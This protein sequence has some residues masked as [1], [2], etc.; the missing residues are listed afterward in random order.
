M[1][2]RLLMPVGSI[3]RLC[4]RHNGA[5][6]VAVTSAPPDLDIAA[7]RA[8][9]RVYLHGLN[10]SYSRSVEASFAVSGMRVSGG[11]VFQIAPEDPR[12]YVSPDQPT[13]FAP[14]EEP[15]TGGGAVR[16]RFPA[17]SVSAVQLEVAAL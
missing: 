15:L 2:V 3:M 4:K 8:N 17:T 12:H 11:R 5:Q 16:W 6:G 9:D 14:K 1:L 10:L 13:V 7:S